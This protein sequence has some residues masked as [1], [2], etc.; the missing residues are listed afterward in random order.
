MSVSP[1]EG[2]VDD[3]GKFYDY[4]WGS[5]TGY[6]YLPYKIPTTG[7]WQKVMFVWPKQRNAVITHTLAQSAE[8]ND[9]YCAPAIFS[10]PRPLRENVKGTHVLWADFD[11][12]VPEG[13]SLGT[14][15]EAHEHQVDGE[16]PLPTLRIQS[17]TENHQHVYWRLD[18]FTTD[19]DFIE[20]TNRALAYTLKADTSGWDLGQ[21]LR[22]P[23][24][25]NY[26]HDLP[27]TVIDFDE[28]ADGYKSA[29]FAHLKPVKQLVSDALD[30]A[31]I[32]DVTRVVAK[33]T[34]DD[35]HYELFMAR[36]I[37]EGHR[38]SALMKIGFFGA[39]SGMSDAEIY[40]LLLNADDRWGKFKHRSDRKRRLLDIINRAR[41][42]H[43]VGL[44]T[45]EGLLR[46]ATDQV[47][48][49]PRY[50]WGF[51]DFL[52]SE[53]KVEWALEGFL[54][55]GG[56]GMVAASP[57]IGKTQIGLQLAICCSLEKP[58]LKWTPARKMK[59]LVLSLEMSPMALKQFVLTIA[60]E[61]TS[62]E[63]Q[64][65]NRNLQLVA[66]GETLPLDHPDGR[67]FLEA[68]LDEHKPDGI[69]IDSLGKLTYKSMNDEEKVKEINDYLV[70]VRKKYGCFLFIIHHNR[71]P[72]EN[73]KKPTDLSDI[74]GN[75]Y[76]AAEASMVAILWREKKTEKR[77]E[78]EFI[79]AKNRLA[80]EMDPFFIR[81]NNHLTFSVMSEKDRAIAENLVSHVGAEPVTPEPVK[82]EPKN[83]SGGSIF[84]F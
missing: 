39:E 5:E 59:I 50:V 69:I 30:V 80:P 26:K 1:N 12:S 13:W 73:N 14:S 16:T 61:Y 77:D 71:K 18:E 67:K 41:Q 74:Y 53:I 11:G 70:K 68:L 47:D 29:R 83:E 32:P 46:L 82:E 35:Q 20:N 45:P 58:F 78:I 43:P 63:H 60:P 4:L 10:E 65:L 31:D 84:D 54:E 24:T 8:G 81:R 19:L 72:Q 57:G 33:Y 9:V 22:P 25:T 27:V 64:Q 66:L 42:K 55:K 44:S 21:V 38:S 40:S 28:T 7:D 49:S 34:F 37:P 6:V 52:H 51:E 36:E 76:I 15:E 2:S 23:S 17:S 62:S 56:I 75:Q 3:L 48:E 79:T